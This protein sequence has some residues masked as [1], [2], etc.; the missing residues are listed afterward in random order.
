MNILG[1]RITADWVLLNN[2]EI[3]TGHVGKS[4]REPLR[5]PA[6]GSQKKTTFKRQRKDSNSEG[7]QDDEEG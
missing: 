1:V 3:L 6:A 5:A 2:F 7:I 4:P